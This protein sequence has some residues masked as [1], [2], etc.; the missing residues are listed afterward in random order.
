MKEKYLKSW[1]IG[2]LT[3]PT[4]FFLNALEINMFEILQMKKKCTY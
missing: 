4:T 3:L 1:G 2:S